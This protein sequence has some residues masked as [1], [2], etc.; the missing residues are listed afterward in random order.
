MG[1]NRENEKPYPSMN[2]KEF[3]ICGENAADSVSSLCD[4][5]DSTHCEKYVKY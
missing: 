4:N 5:S 2:A 1:Y 3:A